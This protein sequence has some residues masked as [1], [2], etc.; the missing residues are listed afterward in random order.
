MTFSKLQFLS[1]LSPLSSNPSFFYLITSELSTASLSWQRLQLVL[2]HV[3]NFYGKVS[4][5]DGQLLVSYII[6][7]VRFFEELW[8]IIGV[9]GFF[10]TR[11]TC[12]VVSYINMTC[13]FLECIKSTST[14]EQI[15]PKRMQVLGSTDRKPGKTNRFNIFKRI[16]PNLYDILYNVGLQKDMHCNTILKQ[17]I[18]PK[19][20]SRKLM[21]HVFTMFLSSL[22]SVINC[23]YLRSSFN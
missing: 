5:R 16:T 9:S 22:K 1:K 12:T 13:L 4:S 2:C 20:I 23:F 10:E 19:T 18:A 14:H 8:D 3:N 17:E 7:T 21:C 11:C 6:D 15:K